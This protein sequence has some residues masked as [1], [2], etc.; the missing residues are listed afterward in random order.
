MTPRAAMPNDAAADPPPASNEKNI[1][2][3][4]IGDY[5][6]QDA[7][8]WFIQA[9]SIFSLRGMRSE[10]RKAQLLIQAL[11]REIFKLLLHAIN[12]KRREPEYTAIKQELLD[13][14]GKSPKNQAAQIFSYI[15]SPT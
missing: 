14:H 3:L 1:K 4:D 15:G 9:E 10:T 8:A 2:P 12:L 11:P 6:P 5:D 7:E 13:M